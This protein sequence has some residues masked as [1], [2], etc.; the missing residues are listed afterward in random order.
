[1]TGSHHLL[2]AALVDVLLGLQ[3]SDS[4]KRQVFISFLKPSEAVYK[5]CKLKGL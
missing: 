5:H 1:M 4:L 2:V 3:G